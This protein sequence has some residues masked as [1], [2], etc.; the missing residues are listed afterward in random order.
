MK[1]LCYVIV[2]L[3]YSLSYIKLHNIQMLE[4]FDSTSNTQYDLKP[5]VDIIRRKLKDFSFALRSTS[6]RYLKKNVDKK[7][8]EAG[9]SSGF[10]GGLFGGSGTDKKVESTVLIEKTELINLHAKLINAQMRASSAERRWRTLLLNIK[11][12]ESLLDGT[13]RAQDCCWLGIQEYGCSPESI[14]HIEEHYDE[15]E[16]GLCRFYYCVLPFPRSFAR[17]YYHTMDNVRLFWRRR[18]YRHACRFLALLCACASGLILYSELTM[19]T[20]WR[21]PIGF[22]LVNMSDEGAGI[23]MVQTVSFL[24]LL[25]MSF[26]TFYSFFK[27]NFGWSFTLQ[28]REGGK[29]GRR[30]GERERGGIARKEAVRV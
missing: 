20:T 15:R 24:Y 23:F 8:K 21:S 25:Y 30:E 3:C 19:L 11:G 10:F 2:T 26:C 5:D 1:I 9:E 13:M 7:K 18:V 27:M 12:E 4:A 28:V 29:K 17:N 16:Q 14:A 22:L 6:T